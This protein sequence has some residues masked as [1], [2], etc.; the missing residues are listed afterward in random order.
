MPKL[1]KAQQKKYRPVL[2]DL[3]RQLGGKLT[4]M[5]ESV[6]MG[7]GDSSSDEGDDLGGESSS[8]EF[9][10]GLLENED[11][12]MQLVR[13]SLDRLDEGSFGACESC[14]ELIP[15]RRLEALPYARYCV[16][17][18]THSEAGTLGDD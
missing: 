6:L 11:E 9:Q 7:D 2:L 3:L 5:E 18:Q 13:A 16:P 8:R 12:I 10:L 4:R 15:V 14:T 17:C 1:T